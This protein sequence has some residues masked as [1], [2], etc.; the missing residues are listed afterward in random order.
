MVEVKFGLESTIYP[1]EL[2]SDIA[3]YAE[4][5]GFDSFFMPDHT[6]AFGIKRWAALEAWTVL[7]ALALKTSKIKLGTAVGDVYRRHPSQ[8][9]QMVTTCDIISRGRAI[10]GVGI[11]EAMNLHPFGIKPEKPV[12]LTKEAVK[13]IRLLWTKESVDYEGKYFKLEKAFLQPQPVQKPHPPIWIAA[14]SPLTMRMVA[15]LGDGW[16]PASM[17]PDEY[18]KGLKEI[19]ENAKKH[20]RNPDEIEP[21]LFTYT[22][23]H[24]EREVAKK[25]F[26]LPAKMYFLTRPRILKKLGYDVSDQFDMTKKLVFN[27]EVGKALLEEAKKLP[28]EVLENAPV[29]YG[30]PEDVIE[31]IDKYVKV[32]VR[33]F[34]VNFF[35]RPENLKETLKLFS[36]EVIPHFKE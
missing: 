20:G 16:L 24:R 18:E 4:E 26:S 30:T 33:H 25:T 14:N 27:I 17:F 19:R 29:F 6:V 15:E 13:V 34:V 11:G 2:I 35:V 1:W 5:V 3:V 9:A 31:G 36:E 10:L 21:A 23:V 22:V 12:G 28:D 32:G 8:L 7:T